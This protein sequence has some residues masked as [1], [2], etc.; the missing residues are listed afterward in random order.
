MTAR[1][2]VGIDLVARDMASRE[3]HA[4]GGSLRDLSGQAQSTGGHIGILGGAVKTMAQGAF[5]YFGVRAV[6]QFTQVVASVPNSIIG[7]NASLEK[8]TLQFET[9]F[10]DADRAREHVRMLFE[11]A[12]ATPFETEP[13]INASR[14]LQTFGGD[15]LNTQKYLTMVGDAAAGAS[16]DIGQVGFWV[17]RAYAA[18]QGGQPF[19]EAR[20][21][22]QELALLS[23]QAA[24]RMEDLQKAGASTTEVWK[25]MEAELSKFSGAMSKQA[26]TWGGLSST[27]SDTFGLTVADSFKGTFDLI[28]DG[29]RGMISLLSNP[30]FGQFLRMIN[31]GIVKGL[32]AVG[33]GFATVRRIA[34]PVLQELAKVA[35]PVVQAVGYVFDVLRSGDDVVWG[36]RETLG[37]LGERLLALATDVGPGVIDFFLTLRARIVEFAATLVSG[38]LQWVN[39]LLPQ[40]AAALPAIGDTIVQFI[41]DYVATMSAQLMQWGNAFFAWVL[42]ALPPLIDNLIF[43]LQ[44]MIDW[45]L[46][47]GVPTLASNLGPMILTMAEWVLKALPGL[48]E[49]LGKVMLSIIN[50]IVDNRVKIVQTLVQWAKSFVNWIFDEA[51]PLLVRNLPSILVAILTFL[52]Q[53]VPKIVEGAVLI[54]YALITGFMDLLLGPEGLAARAQRWFLGDLIPAILGFGGQLLNAGLS[55]GGQ[56]ARGFA[57]A[58]IG[59]VESGI[60]AIIRGINSFISGI[61]RVIEALPGDQG[62]DTIGRLGL[63]SLPRFATGSWMIPKDMLAILHAGEMVVPR[64]IAQRVRGAGVAAGGGSGFTGFRGGGAGMVVHQSF[65]F[66]PGSV[67]SDDDIR[68]LGV[69]MQERA[70]LQGFAATSREIG[71]VVAA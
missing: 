11:F 31:D 18:I 71:R 37:N 16:T 6:Q 63:V 5:L 32:R 61:N 60:N 28:K 58:L 15:A 1:S 23:P 8:S 24:Q 33:E 27:L 21:R 40:L 22:L 70:Q 66:G 57:N 69:E 47:T 20:M 34:T 62:Y 17:G 2:T 59:G 55:L 67:R 56:L 45:V 14:I 44:A 54:A 68:R 19:G 50:F 29:L 43:F 25:I 13:V 30:A 7:M 49:G 3:V 51:L 38:F 9:L 53:A 12:K 39:D 52:V 41:T 4:V 35:A 10:K 48:I 65:F 64:D 46:E 26:E 42:E 36:L